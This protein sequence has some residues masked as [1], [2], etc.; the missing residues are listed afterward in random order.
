MIPTKQR[1]LTRKEMASSPPA[2]R[3]KI[4]LLILPR[5]QISQWRERKTCTVL[6]K[7][8]KQCLK[9]I[10][11]GS[12]EMRVAIQWN[13]C[14][15]TEIDS[16]QSINQSINHSIN[17]S[18]NQSIN[19]W[20]DQAINQSR[21]RMSPYPMSRRVPANMVNPIE[22]FNALKQRCENMEKCQPRRIEMK[23]QEN[24]IQDVPVAWDDR[25][26]VPRSRSRRRVEPR[27]PWK[28]SVHR[29]L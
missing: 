19:R 1:M 26:P 9:V 5:R 7:W 3:R 2:D 4:P 20:I 18:T 24:V 29:E 21:D 25:H 12:I 11:S 22:Y 15:K 14:P 17:H 10:P 16:S 28:W 23:L 8:S 6:L 13:E 27:K